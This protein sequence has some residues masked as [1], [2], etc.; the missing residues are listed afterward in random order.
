MVKKKWMIY[1]AN[2][3]TGELIAR[4]AK[5]LGMDVILGG[6]NGPAVEKLAR[7]LGFSPRIFGLDDPMGIDDNIKD[8]ALVLHCAG[9][10]VV[11]SRPM[12]ESCI[13]TG[14]HYLDITGEIPV[15]Q[16]LYDLD[17]A[18]KK[19]SVMLLPGVGFDIV[20]TDCMAAE[21]KY[22]MKDAATLRLGFLA[23]GSL[24]GGTARSALLQM[25]SGLKVR[26]EG[27]IRTLPHLSLKRE[28]RMAG[29]NYTMYAIPWGDVF[30][31]YI[32]TGIP[33]VEVYSHLPAG[34]ARAMGFML[35]LL[36]FFEKSG[37][38]KA[39]SGLAGSLIEGPGETVRESSVSHVWG[40]VENKKGKSLEL[41]MLTLE[42]YKFTIE[43]SLLAVK[44]TL[45]GKTKKGFTTPSLAFGRKFVLE[46]PGTEYRK[47]PE[48]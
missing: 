18:A 2:G 1:G 24:S 16:A 9:P 40:R 13:R 36:G 17:S 29:K 27:Q 19:A 14:T 43:S 35:P 22:R 15:Y 48:S 7:E 41:E 26:R 11:T 5:E 30:T 21:L 10:F 8:L 23:L 33:D 3:Y 34:Q 38:L 20:P 39:A 12:A 46:V 42:G 32:S 47:F 31:S 37:L 28:V 25:G 6:R 44:K 4:Q 45:S